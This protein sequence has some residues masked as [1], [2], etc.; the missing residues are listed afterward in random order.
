MLTTVVSVPWR[1][2]C[3][4]SDREIISG[5]KI[6]VFKSGTSVL[7]T[8]VLLIK[9]LRYFSN[10]L[11]YFDKILVLYDETNLFI[12]DEQTMIILP[13]IYL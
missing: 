12:Y 2:Y 10:L 8:S 4:D 9:T 5:S 1:K 13:T 3:S 11:L 6:S 7:C